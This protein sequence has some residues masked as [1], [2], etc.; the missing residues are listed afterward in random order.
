M[1]G[2]KWKKFGPPAG[3]SSGIQFAIMTSR[4][5]ET[6]S[7]KK[8]TS[9]LSATGSLLMRGRFPV[10]RGESGR[11]QHQGRE[12][13]T[14]DARVTERGMSILLLSFFLRGRGPTGRA[15]CAPGYPREASEVRAAVPAGFTAGA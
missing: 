2:S 1:L 10:A 5:G 6:G 15:A 12:G 11:R 8:Y 9:V 13:E 7:R 3:S 14:Q 4:E